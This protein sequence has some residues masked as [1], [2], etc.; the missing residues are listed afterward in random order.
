METTVIINEQHTLLEQ[1]ARILN[2]KFGDFQRLL[3]PSEGW[4]KKE[5][6]HICDSLSG[7][8][9]FVSPIPGMIQRLAADAA[10]NAA[11]SGH[12]TALRTF[13]FSNDRR[14]KKE[15]PN[16]RIISVTAQEGW[17]LE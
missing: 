12:S 11:E 3:V 2:E 15:L 1:Q 10:A 13:V 6:D 14:E 7:N 5:R 17:Y 16:G 8:V 9:I 4:N